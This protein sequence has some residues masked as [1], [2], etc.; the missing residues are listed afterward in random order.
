MLGRRAALETGL[1]QRAGVLH[2]GGESRPNIYAR[3]STPRAN[4]AF[5]S[6]SAADRLRPR[7][8]L[9]QLRAVRS[10][11]RPTSLSS[12]PPALLSPSAVA[13]CMAPTSSAF[14]RR[15]SRSTRSATT[16]LQ[17]SSRRSERDRMGATASWETSERNASGTSRLIRRSSPSASKSSRLAATPSRTTASVG[18]REPRREHPLRQRAADGLGMLDQRHERVAFAARDGVDRQIGDRHHAL[19]RPAPRSVGVAA[20]GCAPAA[21][22]PLGAAKAARLTA[23]LHL[24]RIHAQP[25]RQVADVADDRARDPGCRRRRA[26]TPA[27]RPPGPR[28]SRGRAR[29]A[30]AGS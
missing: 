10:P 16:C 9:A 13:R 25:P 24:L 4:I 30:A 1:T 20:F 14:S 6:A 19:G 22:A 27:A 26:R 2:S 28:R 7:S 29:R 12:R 18:L 8:F 23:V 17:Y 3:A 11:A 5:G 21:R 15:M